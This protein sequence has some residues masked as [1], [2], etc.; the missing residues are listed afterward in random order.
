MKLNPII[1]ISDLMHLMQHSWQCLQVIHF[2]G[3]RYQVITWLHWWVRT[4][5]RNRAILSII[6][7]FPVLIFL[8]KQHNG[9]VFL[10]MLWP[11]KW[12]RKTDAVSEQFDMSNPILGHYE[13][14]PMQLTAIF[15]DCKN[16]N[17]HLKNFDYFLLFA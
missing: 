9:P 6:F 10:R 12:G 15:H 1:S 8:N 2:S 13:N 11:S 14:T 7:A 5:I 17:F 16:D 3:L 4:D